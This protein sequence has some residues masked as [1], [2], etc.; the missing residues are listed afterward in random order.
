MG[1]F[2]IL[3][4]DPQLATG[5]IFSGMLLAILFGAYMLTYQ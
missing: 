2:A 4:P 3:P 1:A 5:V